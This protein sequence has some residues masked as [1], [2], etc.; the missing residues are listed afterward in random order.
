MR[1]SNARKEKSPIANR[2]RG[3]LPVVVD[4]ETGGFNPNTDALLEI[5]GVVIE[6]QE[7]GNLK[8]GETWR[9]HVQ[10]FAGAN[11]EAASLAVNGID[12]FHPLRPALPES[13]ALT[14]LLGDIRRAVK[15]SGCNRAVLVGHNAYFDLNFLNAAVTR[16]DIKRNPFHPFSCFDTAT[17]GGVAF[18][19]TVLAKLALAAGVEWDSSEAHSAAYDAEITADLFCMICNRFRGI[20]ETSLLTE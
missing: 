13:E 9:Y 15:D 17:L 6:M 14:R 12:P 1:M 2:F 20:Y 11:M 8:R 16:C 7:D 5:A 19:Q 18:G 10:P 4:V 3:F